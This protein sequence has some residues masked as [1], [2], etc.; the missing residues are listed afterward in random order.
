MGWVRTVLAA[1]VLSVSLSPGVAHA[2]DVERARAL[3]G[4]ARLAYDELRFG[5]A[6]A[7]FSASQRLD[8]TPD[9]A[10]DLALTATKLGRF[11][12]ASRHLD[13]ALAALPPHH[14]RRPVAEELR[15]ELALRTPLLWI[16]LGAPAAVTLDGRRVS[17]HELGSPIAIDPGT[18]EIVIRAAGHED[19]RRVLTVG[20][21]ERPT[22]RAVPGP[23][24]DVRPTEPEPPPTPGTPWWGILGWSLAGAGVA[25]LSATPVLA[26]LIIERDTIVD[27]H[28]DAARGCDDIAFAAADEGKQLADAGTATFVVGVTALAAGL[29]L[30]IPSLLLDGDVAI[31]PVSGGGVLSIAVRR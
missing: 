17:P 12:Q 20:E 1:F 29:G 23:P 30:A 3:H 15:T 18:H 31:T 5:A 2:G 27:E 6:Y 9:K 19:N 13:E 14:E 8:P 28:C 11:I 22:I 16:E 21:H 4:D 24:L 25:S 7:L 10:L 26:G